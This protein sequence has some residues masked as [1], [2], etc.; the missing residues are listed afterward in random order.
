M[1]TASASPS[2]RSLATRVLVTRTSLGA[3]HD[4][5]RRR[6]YQRG[7]VA[8]LKGRT[9]AHPTGRDQH[10]EDHP[11]RDPDRHLR[12][13]LPRGSGSPAS[14]PTS[15]TARRPA[16]PWCSSSPATTRSSRPATAR[17]T[18]VPGDPRR[19]G[20]LRRRA[21]PPAARSRHEHPARR[22]GAGDAEPD[23]RAPP[24]AADV[25]W[26]PRADRHPGGAPCGCRPARPTRSA[27]AWCPAPCSSSA[28]PPTVASTTQRVRRA[29][30]PGAAPAG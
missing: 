1:S 28:W 12:A 15:S 9:S 21:R 14:W 3:A 16:V 30:S 13:D 27:S 7:A 2:R 26:L 8:L 29:P 18:S 6:R 23:R 17:A 5:G 24:A 20:R 4:T 25:G 22:R 11:C 10:S 19:H